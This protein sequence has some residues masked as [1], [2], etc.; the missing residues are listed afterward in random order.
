V[1]A[2]A[3]PLAVRGYRIMAYVTGVVLIVLCFVGIPLQAFAHDLAVVKYV[4]T[5]HGF[6]YIVYVIV[7]FA[8]TRLVGMKVASPATV[9]VLLAGTIPVLTF[10]VERWITRR[11]I[12]PALAAAAGSPAA[13][14]R[15]AAGGQQA[16]NGPAGAQGQAGAPAGWR[17]PGSA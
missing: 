17:G 1:R 11:Y 6:L 15:P 12:T 3:L 2:G 4:G 8:M 13:G 7:A 14:S 10:V 16:G 9:I 5:A